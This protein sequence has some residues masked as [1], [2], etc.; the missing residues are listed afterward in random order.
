MALGGASRQTF[1]GRVV[2][3]AQI[4]QGQ[5]GAFLTF[6]LLVDNLVRTKE[7]GRESGRISCSY[8]IRGDNP[9]EDRNVVILAN[10]FNS[11]TGQGGLAGQTY[12]SVEAQIEGTLDLVKAEGGGVWYNLNFVNI[13]ITDNN[14][15]G[16]YRAQTGQ[17]QQNGQYQQQRTAPAQA[18]AAPP[19]GTTMPS[20][21]AAPG[22]VNVVPGATHQANAAQ[23]AAQNLAS[24]SQVLGGGQAAT[25]SMSTVDTSAGVQPQASVASTPAASV[26]DLLQGSPPNT[27]GVAFTG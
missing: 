5:K 13:R 17:G 19:G 8:T 14:I 10:V 27:A 12:K 23:Q 15:L 26:K 16:L 4:R 21:G 1:F 11:E 25:P 18:Q 3:P 22:N 9:A 7:G 24:Q 20:A 2:S 6:D